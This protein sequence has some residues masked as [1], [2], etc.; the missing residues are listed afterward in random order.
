MIPCVGLLLI[1]LVSSCYCFYGPGDDVVQ[2]T[3]SNFHKLVIESNELWLVEFYATSCHTCI[4]FAPKW[5]EAASALKGVVKCGAVDGET[6]GGLFQEYGINGVPTVLFFGDDKSMYTEYDIKEENRTLVE[7]AQAE[8]KKLKQHS[9]TSIMGVQDS[10][11]SGYTYENY[12]VGSQTVNAGNNQYTVQKQYN[13]QEN[14]MAVNSNMRGQTSNVRGQTSNVRGQTSNVRGQTSNVR[15]QTSTTM[16]GASSGSEQINRQTYNS[17]VRTSS[18]AHSPSSVTQQ[19]SSGH[20]GI[21]K[22]NSHASNQATYTG[23]SQHRGT[24]QAQAYGN[25]KVVKSYGGSQPSRKTQV[26]KTHE[27]ATNQYSV[28]TNNKAVNSNV[29]GQTSNV[30]GQTSTVR[31]QTSNVRGQ[32]SNVRGQ[33]SNVRGQTSNVIDQTSN[34]RGQTSNVRGQTSN[35]RGQTSNVRGQTSNVRGQ[36]SNVIGQTSNVRGQTSNVRGQTST[37]MQGAS[38]GRSQTYDGENSQDVILLT[39]QNF[40]EKVLK[41]DDMWLVEFYDRNDPQSQ[42]LAPEWSSAASVLKGRVQLGKCD[43]QANRATAQRYEIRSV[44]TIKVFPAGKKN[45][46]CF[47]YNEGQTV[48]DIVLWTCKSNPRPKE[49]S[50]RGGNNEDVVELTDRNFY[51]KVLMSDEV[52]LVEFYDLRNSRCKQ[53]APAWS[54]SATALRGQANLGRYDVT[55]NKA[56]A[57]IYGVNIKDVPIIKYF[58]AGRKNGQCSDYTEGNSVQEVVTWGCKNIQRPD[59]KQGDEDVNNKDLIELTDSNFYERV[60]RSDD[61]WLVEFYDGNDPRSHELAP[62]WS[63]AATVLKA[64]VNMGR[65]DVTGNGAIKQTYGIQSVPTFKVFPAGKKDGRCLDFND[66][67]TCQRIIGWACKNIERPVKQAYGD[68]NSKD[69]IVLTD[70]NFYDSVLRSDDMWLV[71]FYD[72]QSFKCRELVPQWSSAAT[73]LKGQVNL[74][75]VEVNA[76]RAI[77]QAYRITDTPSIKYFPA[78][79]KDGQCVDYTEGNDY[80]AIVK[81]ARGY[82]KHEQSYDLDGDVI[83]LTDS[84]FEESVMNSYD[85]WFVDFYDPICLA[86]QKFNPEWSSAA[87]ALKGKVKMGKCDFTINHVTAQKCNIRQTPSVLVCKEGKKSL[88]TFSSY[89]G[90][91]QCETFLTEALQTYTGTQ[92]QQSYDLDGDV[93][94]LT[95]SN[96]EESVMNSYDEWFVDFY[97][98]NN[99]ACQSFNPKWSSAATT[100]KGKVKMGKCDFTRNPATA[101]RCNIQHIP[102]VLHCNLGKKSL[103]MFSYYQGIEQCEYILNRVL[104]TYGRTPQHQQFE[105]ANIKS[106][107]L[108]GDVIVLTDSNFEESVMNSDDE[109]FV[110]FYNPNCI[111]CQKFNPEWSSAATALKGKVKMGK[112]DITINHVTAQKCNIRQ[113]PSVLVCKEGKKSLD[114][115]S[116]YQGLEQCET[117]LTEALQTYT[118]TQQQQTHGVMVALTDSNFDEYVTNSNDKWLVNFYNP[119]CKPCQDFAKKFS[120]AD[121]V[122]NGKFM[123]GEYDVTRNSVIKARYGIR[124]TPTVLFCHRERK[125]ETSF[126]LIK[127]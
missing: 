71:Q 90:L 23:N 101:Q 78:G 50:L 86:C 82:S 80:D 105:S 1:C 63:S 57:K 46:K 56:I 106:Y 117:F 7:F 93:F 5:K 54:F 87:T 31:G 104:N 125:Q 3:F 76:N 98:P 118:G 65:Y 9:S 29:R 111:P 37:T 127:E 32:T 67:E 97:D 40:N 61:M 53:L 72:L 109:W 95:D 10:Q 21:Q 25:S 49:Q 62:E 68:E 34:V 73:E 103:D 107:D 89:Q 119:Q 77:V 11:M 36:T 6:Q 114:T 42:K 24:E 122:M 12:D 30:R 84:N 83:V 92:P 100:L 33:T 123:T 13:E 124:S 41:S 44:P 85:E 35:V 8:I 64:K 17:E 75:V 99:L 59:V 16:Q 115:F 81:W 74:G 39:D 70:S 66:G 120:S 51:D 126:Y 58:Q 102:S 52:W 22:M 2:L 79:M 43:F 18:S 28:Q 55:A 47:D 20:S 48:K 113:T 116:S 94:V 45:G 38:S 110:D 4:V 60:L 19:S 91:E 14:T 112:C 88:D 121:A 27:T 69:V 96:F 15:G 26:G 108:D